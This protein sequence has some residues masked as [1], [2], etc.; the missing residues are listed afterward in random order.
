MERL[1]EHVI[2]RQKMEYLEWKGLS[3]HEAQVDGGEEIYRQDQ[4][5]LIM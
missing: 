1:V 2:R 5:K 4:S 3:R